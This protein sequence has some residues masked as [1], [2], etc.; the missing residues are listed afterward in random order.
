MTRWLA[1]QE[2]KGLRRKPAGDQYL[3]LVHILE[4][5]KQDWN[6]GNKFATTYWASAL[7][8]A[9]SYV[10]YFSCPIEFSQILLKIHFIILS[11]QMRKWCSKR[12]KYLPPAGCRT[13]IG[14]QVSLILSFFKLQQP[15]QKPWVVGTPWSCPNY[16]IYQR[17]IGLESIKWEILQMELGETWH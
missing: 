12:L 10:L 7:S 11:F 4:W 3:P 5:L 1:N 2:R 6:R 8:Q 15:L 13:R 16:I 9:L 17:H 14:F